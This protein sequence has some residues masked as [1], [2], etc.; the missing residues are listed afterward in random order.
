MIRTITIGDFKGIKSGKVENLAALTILVGHNDSGK[1][2]VLDAVHDVLSGGVP[3]DNATVKFE[4]DS[5]ESRSYPVVHLTTKVLASELKTSSDSHR[6]MVELLYALHL[7]EDST[8]Q[9]TLIDQPEL[10]LD[11]ANIDRVAAL[12]WGAVRRGV[13]V[14]CATH[15]VS[16]MEAIVGMHCTSEIVSNALLSEQIALVRLDL[17]EGVL[18]TVY[19]N[20]NDLLMAMET[21]ADI[22]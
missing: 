6:R 14:I 10:F 18:S 20:G 7:P 3:P 19:G 8:G 2:T 22:R 13:Q 17:K 9:T 5:D 16:F 15:S 11:E 12:I 21:G 1:S 4:F